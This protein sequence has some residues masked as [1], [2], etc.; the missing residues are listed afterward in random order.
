MADDLKHISNPYGLNDE[1][2]FGKHKDARVKDIIYNDVKYIEWAL[3]NV[4]HF[5][6]DK[7]A[8]DYYENTWNAHNENENDTDAFFYDENY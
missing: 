8:L 1:I 7:D 3:E 5:D 6:I 2:N 4:D